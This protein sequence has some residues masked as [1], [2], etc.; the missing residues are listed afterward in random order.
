MPNPPLK[1]AIVPVTPLQQNCTLLWCTETNKGAFVDPGGDLPRLKAAA[2]QAGVEIEKILITHGHIDHCGQ[3]A[4]L[5]EELGVPIEGP[6]E[7]DRFWIARLEDDGRTY[8]ICG[9]VFESDRW[10]VDGDQVTVGNLT[11]DVRHCPGHTPGHV[12]FHHA[13]SKLAIVGD[14][15][16]QGSIGRTD[17]P[18]GNH[19]DLLNAITTRLWPMGNETAFVPGHGP[20]ST[21]G[22]E[23]KTNPF[24]ADRV[25]AS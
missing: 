7:A 24:V 14:V 25:L 17:F 11:L 10:L 2:Q 20:M 5:A 22:H 19:A 16:F 1:A 6:H 13:P 21:F 4:V 12:V 23:R 18:M 3:A 8:G 9:K 15:L